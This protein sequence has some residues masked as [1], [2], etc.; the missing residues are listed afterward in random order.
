M[1]RLPTK[2]HLGIVGLSTLGA[3]IAFAILA[4]VVRLSGPAPV[5]ADDVPYYSRPFEGGPFA[6]GVLQT[7]DGLLGDPHRMPAAADCKSCHEQAFAE[8]STS[9]HSMAGIETIYERT[10]ERNMESKKRRHGVELTR[11]CESCHQPIELAMGR[12]NPLPSVEPSPASADGVSCIVCHTTQAS[13]P[14]NG[15]GALTYAFNELDRADLTGFLLAAPDRH[16]TEMGRGRDLLASGD[17]CGGCHTQ[18]DIPVVAEVDEVTPTQTT[19]AEWADSWYAANGVTCQNCHMAEE[20]AA[21]IQALRHG[22]KAPPARVSHAFVGTNYL[23]TDIDTFGDALYFLRGGVPA[24]MTGEAMKPL[25][26]TQHRRTEE[27]L[28]AAAEVEVTDAVI[29]N[30]GSGHARVTVRNVG[31]GHAIPS[32][33]TDQKYM[34]LELRV[35]DARG[36]LV[37][38][39]GAF[40]PGNGTIPDDSVVWRERFLDRAGREITDHITFQTRTVEHTRPAIP[41]RGEATVAFDLALADG[42]TPP[43]TVSAKLWY[44]VATQDLIARALRTDRVMPPFLM[45]E[46]T[47]RLPTSLSN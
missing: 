27:L 6:P 21:Y 9:L 15:N 44:R 19:Y 18:T 37:Y 45:A 7:A 35:T 33:V 43:F 22:D 23:L 34:W 13:D 28:R 41:P 16:A 31:A 4:V 26:R 46:A 2:P 8:W 5:T 11:Y 39:H 3:A 24:G 36:A 30:G 17:L 32:G 47:A 20:P 25:L 42:A 38:D 40:N 29:A 10:E 1:I 12:I 14:G